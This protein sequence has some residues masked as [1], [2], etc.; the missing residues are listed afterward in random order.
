MVDVVTIAETMALVTPAT[1]GKLS[2]VSPRSATQ[3]GGAESNV[4]ISLGCP[5]VAALWIG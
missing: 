2:P 5:G 3:V 4:V 1:V